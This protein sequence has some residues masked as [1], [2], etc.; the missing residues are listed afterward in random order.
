MKPQSDPQEDEEEESIEEYMAG[1]LSRMRGG[2]SAPVVISPESRRNKRKS[3]APPPEEQEQ[4][5]PRRSEPVP[6][7]DMSMSP[8]ELKRRSQPLAATDLT[9]MRELANIQARQAIDTHG[10]KRSLNRAYGTFGTSV[11]CLVAGFIVLGLSDAVVMRA[12]GMVIL[13]VGIYWMVSGLL[14]A[15]DVFATMRRKTTGLRAILEEVEAEIAANEQ[16]AAQNDT[17]KRG[18]ES[19]TT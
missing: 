16:E 19:Q 1:L 8:G 17:D 4:G 15:R 7:V 10:Q 13:V 6:V 12:S 3:D 11:A 2:N 18:G 5:A 9:A 14:A